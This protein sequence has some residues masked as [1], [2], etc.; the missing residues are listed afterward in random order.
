MVVYFWVLIQI[1]FFFRD[2]LS[3]ISKQNHVNFDIFL[4]AILEGDQE[5]LDEVDAGKGYQNPLRQVMNIL[6]IQI[7]LPVDIV[8]VLESSALLGVHMLITLHGI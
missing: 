3:G 4:E 6:P 2:F 1:L 8:Q 5:F 7:Q